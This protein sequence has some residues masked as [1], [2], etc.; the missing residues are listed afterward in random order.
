MVLGGSNHRHAASGKRS[1]LGIGHTCVTVTSLLPTTRICVKELPEVGGNISFLLVLRNNLIGEFSGFRIRVEVDRTMT[2]NYYSTREQ[3]YGHSQ[4]ITSIPA[5]T[6]LTRSPGSELRNLNKE[7]LM[8]GI[9][10]RPIPRLKRVYIIPKRTPSQ[11]I[12]RQ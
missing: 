7:L 4:V 2:E 1:I 9:C 5:H 8:L 12:G 10:V 11:L 6:H 3:S